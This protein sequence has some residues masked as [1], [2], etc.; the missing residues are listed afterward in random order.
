MSLLKST[1]ELAAEIGVQ[2]E[3]SLASREMERIIDSVLAG[4]TPILGEFKVFADGDTT[5]SVLG[6]RNFRTANTGS[7]VLIDNLDD[8]Q[9]GQWVFIHFNDTF[10]DIDFTSSNMKGNNGANFAAQV[11]DSMIAIFDGTNWHCFLSRA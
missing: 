7:T 4:V 5:P 6:G 3:R 11:D 8:G 1:K 9:V 2:P 10:T